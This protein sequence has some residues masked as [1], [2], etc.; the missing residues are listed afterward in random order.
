MGIKTAISWTRSTA[1]FWWGCTEVSAG[2]D[3]CYARVLAH[4]MGKEVWGAKVPRLRLSEKHR[5][6]PLKWEKKA[7]ETGEF[8]PVFCGS[9]MDWADAEVPQEWVTE[10]FDII[11]ATPHLTWQMLTKRANRIAKLLPSDWDSWENVWMGTSVESPKVEWRIEELLKIPAKVHWV[12]GEPLLEDVNWSPWFE[13]GLDWLVIGGESQQRARARPFEMDWARN[14][15]RQGL[16]S[17]VPIFIKQKG[18]N[19]PGFKFE[20]SHGA[21]PAEWPLEC[22]VREFP[23]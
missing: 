18:S 8:W 5:R 12:S 13:K 14:A 10:I 23:K 3:S 15:I 2:C 16:E 21:N 11:R 19:V 1:N 6:E 7:K 4:R 20:D 9:M 17:R 22:Q